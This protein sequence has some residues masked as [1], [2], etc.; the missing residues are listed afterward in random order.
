MTTDTAVLPPMTAAASA[1]PEPRSRLAQLGIDTGYVLLGFP[2][3]IAA[4]VLVVTGLALGAGLL[5]IWVG[6][7]VLALTLLAARGLATVERAQLPAVLE[8]PRARPRLPA[9]PGP[10]PGPSP[11]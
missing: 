9:A 6:V 2:I 5:V 1:L 10:T 7:P 11:G 3:A 4:F 8:R